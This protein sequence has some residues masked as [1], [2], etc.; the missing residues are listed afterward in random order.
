MLIL[1]LIVA[2][3]LIKFNS[4]VTFWSK[5]MLMFSFLFMI[6][7]ET[8]CIYNIVVESVWSEYG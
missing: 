5:I 4:D 7:N 6:A 1:I 8:N 2:N 3:P